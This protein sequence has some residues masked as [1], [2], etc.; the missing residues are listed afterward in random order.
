[1]DQTEQDR[2]LQTRGGCVSGATQADICLVNAM[3][4]YIGVRPPSP[5][6]LFI[7]GMAT[8]LTRKLLVNELHAAL[9]LRGIPHLNIKATA[10]GLGQAPQQP[11]AVSKTRYPNAGKVV[12]LCISYLHKN[13]SAGTSSYI[14]STSSQQLLTHSE[15]SY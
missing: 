15:D 2:S 3:V 10:L 9:R 8:P 4:D 13:P 12:E 1:M 6:P 14:S 7:T 11:G 5:G